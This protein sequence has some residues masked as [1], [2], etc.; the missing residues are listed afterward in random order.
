V[1][2]EEALRNIIEKTWA[3]TKGGGA[4]HVLIVGP[5]GMGK[6][7]LVCFLHHYISR[8]IEPRP[9]LPGPPENWDPLLFVEEEYAANNT[10]ANFLLSLCSKLREADPTEEAWSLPETLRDQSDRTVTDCCFERIQEFSEKRSRKLLVLVDNIQ[11]ILQQFHAGD[12]HRFRSLLMDQSAILLVG[13]APWLFKEV[14]AYREPFFEFFET[15]YLLD[16]TEEET[17]RLLEARF[18]E[19]GLETDFRRREGNLRRKIP[20]IRKLTGGNPR[21]ILFLYQIITRSAFLE[22][23]SA[24]RELIEELSDYFR[25]RYDALADQPRKVL[26]TLAQME[27]PSTPT[28]IAR[29]ARISVQKVNAQLKRLKGWGYVEPVKHERKRSTHYD[30]TERLFRIWRQT[31]TVAGRQRFK[32]LAQFLKIYYTPEEMVEI[33]R[34][35]RRELLTKEMS[36]PK[37][38]YRHAVDDLYY[39]QEAASGA[40]CREIF[41]LRMEVFINLED[42][43]QAEQEAEHFLAGSVEAEDQAGA[44]AAYKIQAEVHAAA[45]RHKEA[46]K[47]VKQLLRLDRDEEAVTAAE[48]VLRKVPSLAEAWALR[49]LAAIGIGNHTKAFE[50]FHKATDLE[51]EEARY[52]GLQA[53]ALRRLGRAAEALPCAEQAVELNPDDPRI[54]VERGQ[55]ASDLGDHAKALESFQ[56]ATT[57]QPKTAQFWHFQAMALGSLGRH[58]EALA[59]AERAVELQ[60]DDAHFWEWRGIA[61]DD[62][63]DHAKGLESFQKATTLQPED[64]RYW[65]LQ[66]RALR[67]LGRHA[68]A[69]ACAE[70]AVELQPDDAHFWEWRGI[71]AGDLGDHAKALESFQKAAALKPNRAGHWHHQAEALQNLDRHAE[72]L[73]CLERAIELQPDDAFHVVHKAWALAYLG[74]TEEALGALAEA[75][76]RG[77]PARDIFHARGSILLLSG[78]F[79]EASQVVEEGLTLASDDWRLLIDREIACACQGE[80]GPRMERL[81]T[82]ILKV[83]SPAYA[84]RRIV[85]FLFDLGTQCTTRGDLEGLRNL[86]S[87]AFDLPWQREDWFGKTLGIYLG[88]LLDAPPPAFEVGIDTV[89]EKI[90]EPSILAL[91]NPYLQAAEYVR[92]GDASI[93][94]RLF[95]EIRELILEIS[96]RLRR[97]ARQAGVNNEFRYPDGKR[98]VANG[99]EAVAYPTEGKV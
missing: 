62:L 80:H 39:F 37:E 27:G 31:A 3:M 46:L 65:R 54:W 69:L 11:K 51:P 44:V 93:L 50:S 81:A 78:R 10:L 7:H 22:V 99:T 75:K 4:K 8:G 63:G 74:R 98:R 60:P 40:L 18:R 89:R 28:E 23:E 58:V 19:D 71:A 15:I 57:L 66:A 17:L 84:P 48:G 12:H 72:A 68:E 9:D 14:I 96:Q 21:L 25:A 45:G 88:K 87:V 76:D 49:G 94:D 79:E 38:N 35:Y 34:S 2:R 1:G 70:R 83:K 73:T 29:A 59:C 36:V 26:D 92:T 97:R 86:L 67:R 16:L 5:R 85:R 43:T 42:Y 24:L 55:A 13:T 91:L 61:A 30:V 33:V 82:A 64:G 90:V 47:D 6:T 95:P 32:L 20:A 52:W 56:K 41:D 77:A 53:L